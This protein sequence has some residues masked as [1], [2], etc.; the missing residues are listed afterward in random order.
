MNQRR[1]E[2]AVYTVAVR[3]R[4]GRVGL[5]GALFLALFVTAGNYKATP[6]LS[7][8]PDLT[9][10]FAI[11]TI[12]ACIQAA[13]RARGRLSSAFHVAVIFYFL[14]CVGLLGIG[15]P[16]SIKMSSQFF[17]LTL[18]A[19]IAPLILMRADGLLASRVLW[20]LALLG[21]YF[22]F[23]ALTGQNQA[24]DY[25]RFAVLSTNTIQ[26]GR[27]TA[28][29][30]IWFGILTF[31]RRIRVIIGLPVAI[32]ASVATVGT[33]SRGPL[34][35]AV[36]VIVGVLMISGGD[37]Q[38]PAGRGFRRVFVL[39][40]VMIAIYAGYSHA[41]EYARS[42]LLVSGDSGAVRILIWKDSLGQIWRHPIGVGYGNWRNGISEYV[43]ERTSP[44]IDQ[45]HNL[46]LEVFIEGGWIAGAV[47]LWFLYR[48]IRA[49]WAGRGTVTGQG[50]F[51]M[52]L[53]YLG[54]SMVSDNLNDARMTF[55]LAGLCLAY[56]NRTAVIPAVQTVH[57]PHVESPPR[58]VAA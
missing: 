4:T 55:M 53:F 43:R 2:R 16:A 31:G 14:M 7:G 57:T 24:I 20:G 17:T 21:C 10:A 37:P 29:A 49:G 30:L 47:L 45:P 11:L 41:P 46:I 27:L 56:A 42:R 12:L 32:L 51:A 9:V 3:Q 1:D 23:L 13:L 34:L 52:F 35:F 18:L 40:A 36:V 28:T 8:L 54:N 38:R 58:A 19:T 5:L 50:L 44:L 15:S 22:T 39:T 25:G 33:G 48:S 6:I 26:T